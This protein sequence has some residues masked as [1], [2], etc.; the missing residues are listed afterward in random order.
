MVMDGA[1][2]CYT[3]TGGSVP[4]ILDAF[5]ISGSPLIPVSPATPCSTGTS[6]AEL[7]VINPDPSVP[8]IPDPA[9]TF[10]VS[11][12]GVAGAAMDGSGNLWI[13]NADTGTTA[14]HGNAL[15]EFIGIGAPVVTPTSL[16]LQFGQVGV[17][18]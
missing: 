15:V 14:S 3:G 9:T 12:N 10:A 17:R 7:P 6:T 2:H 13:L 4:G 5:T 1:G 16:A 11:N 18:P 8:V